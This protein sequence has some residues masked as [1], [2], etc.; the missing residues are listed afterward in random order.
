MDKAIHH[1][2]MYAVSREQLAY[3]TIDKVVAPGG[4]CANGELIFTSIS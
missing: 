1:M 2:C 4:A 3:Q